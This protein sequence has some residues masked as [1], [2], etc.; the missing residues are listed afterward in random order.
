MPLHRISESLLGN[1]AV[2]RAYTLAR[3]LPVF[4]SVVRRWVRHV[5][6][7]GTRRWM[8]VPR[9]LAKGRY[10]LLD[11]RFELHYARGDHEPWLGE[12]LRRW[13]RPGDTFVDVGAHIGY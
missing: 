13:L 11:P 4:G 12:L 8:R 10:M 5:L 3:G 9:G 6:P 7:A 1:L 2:R